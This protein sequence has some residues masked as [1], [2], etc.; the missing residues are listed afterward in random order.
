MA[1]RHSTT[2][3]RFSGGPDRRFPV[4]IHVEK[5]YVVQL[6]G[7]SVMDHERSG[8]VEVEDMRTGDDVDGDGIRVTVIG[9]F[10]RDADDERISLFLRGDELRELV[11]A[12]HDVLGRPD[13]EDL[14]ILH[15]VPRDN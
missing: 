6:T 9:T 11:A 14:A 10:D 4:V 7:R 8:T 1:L 5:T 13:A 12:A 15:G 3:S 2:S